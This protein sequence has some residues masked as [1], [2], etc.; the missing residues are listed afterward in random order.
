MVRF[1]RYD[2]SIFESHFCFIL[3]MTC[4]F[5]VSCSKMTISGTYL[6]KNYFLKDGLT[7][8]YII[9]NFTY[10]ESTIFQLSFELS[11]EVLT[12]SGHL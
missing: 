12:T 10:I 11:I 7:F 5:I 6:K 8:S 1:D 4:C 2:P 9:I 3:N